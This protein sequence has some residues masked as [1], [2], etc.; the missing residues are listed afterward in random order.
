MSQ[1]DVDD[2][3]R[4]EVIY[5]NMGAQRVILPQDCPRALAITYLSRQITLNEYQLP[6]FFYRSDLLPG[7]LSALTQADVD[8]ASVD[9]DYTEGFPTYG[10]GK[11][12][13]HQLPHETFGDYLLFKRYLAQAEEVG[14][15][16]RELLA[17]EESVSSDKVDSLFQEYYWSWRSKAYDFFQV[18]ADRKRREVRRTKTENSHF[19][20][21]EGMLNA[22]I[23]TV[24]EREGGLEKFFANLT[25]K[26]A[27]ECMR[28]LIN[29]QRVSLG[30][31][32]N[33]NQGN[34]RI[35]PLAG[36]GG[37]ELMKDITKNIRAAGEGG[38]ISSNLLILLQD[39]SF[40]LRA[41]N[42]VLEV[43]EGGKFDQLKSAMPS[44]SIE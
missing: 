23:T 6:I 26:D 8:A 17:E 20:T 3:A 12:W 38:G 27:L 36:A 43:R 21:A 19:K 33:G 14:L 30:L 9:L 41:Q 13:W 7:D 18:A 32:Q 31:S 39:P 28:L 40:A 2:Q 4:R 10:S 16:Q 29:I 22:L 37:E 44:A 5:D 34:E 24:E 1:E 15:R 35:D 25:P 42:L 11:T